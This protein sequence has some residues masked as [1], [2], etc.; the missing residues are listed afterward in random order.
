MSIRCLQHD[1][2]LINIEKI[3]KIN[4]YIKNNENNYDI[5]KFCIDGSATLASYGIRLSRDL[6]F[7]YSGTE[8]VSTGF[9]EIDCHNIRLNNDKKSIDDQITSFLTLTLTLYGI[10][11][12]HTQSR[13]GYSIC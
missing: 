7:F 1:N 8:N 12:T 6:D 2:N 9:K 4:N 10:V 13:Q 11:T 3:N 5:N